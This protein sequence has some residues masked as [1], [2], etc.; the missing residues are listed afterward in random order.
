[1]DHV[2]ILRR[3]LRLTWESKALW[4]FGAILFLTGGGSFNIPRGGHTQWRFREGNLPS[5]PE[6]WQALLLG[7][8]CLIAI[9]VII[10]L[11]LK[12]VARTGLYRL[13]D[14]KLI[15]DRAP[16]VRRGFALGWDHRALRLFGIDLIIGVPLFLLALFIIAIAL[17]PLLLLLIDNAGA[18]IF[19]IVLTV[20]LGLLALL[21]LVI[22]GAL[23]GIWHQ[24]VARCAVLDDQS[25]SESLRRGY[26]LFIARWK[27]VLL[28]ALL[29][30]GVAIGW[31]LVMIPVVI[32]VGLGALAAGGAPALLAMTL[33]GSRVAAWAVGLPIGLVTFLLPMA[34]IQ[35]A[36]QAFHATVW[37]ITYREL[38]P[39]VDTIHPIG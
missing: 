31:G 25:W 6:G 12:Y 21:V 34:V 29:M 32:I 20:G 23:V 17:S 2:D 13:I 39:A 9:L 35:G 27:D 10:G 16:E 24:L 14:E 4:L 11:I 33:T 22:I 18:R 26:A 5:L 38:A 28:M 36:Y 30:W 3:S 15:Y 1:M 8:A 37:T 7:A 19:A